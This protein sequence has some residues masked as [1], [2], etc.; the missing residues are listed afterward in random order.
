MPTKW[1]KISTFG[2]TGPKFVEAYLETGERVEIPHELL[3]YISERYSRDT[4]LVFVERRGR[5]FNFVQWVGT[6][7]EAV[8]ALDEGVLSPSE[9]P[10]PILAFRDSPGRQPDPSPGES[11]GR[12]Q[13]QSGGAASYGPNDSEV[14]DFLSAV[15]SLSGDAWVHGVLATRLR[16]DPGPVSAAQAEL[17]KAVA[18]AMSGGMGDSLRAADQH[19]LAIVEAQIPRSSADRDSERLGPARRGIEEVT[20]AAILALV[21]RDKLGPDTFAILYAPFAGFIRSASRHQA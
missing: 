12:A 7:E 14:R 18:E 6:P 9:V 11:D 1:G 8:T 20:R 17:S 13:S 15:V 2:R 10:V 19:A 21:L 5:L 4:P 16:Q 3:R